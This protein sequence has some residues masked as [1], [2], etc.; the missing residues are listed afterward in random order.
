MNKILLTLGLLSCQLI[1]ADTV[2]QY[3]G[4]NQLVQIQQNNH[5]Y[6]YGYYASGQRAYKKNELGN[7]IAFE[8]DVKGNLSN[9]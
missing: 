4:K 1:Y 3:N 8:Y 5:I 2:Y 9:E 6:E 7:Q